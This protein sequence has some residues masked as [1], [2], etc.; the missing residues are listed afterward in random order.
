[1][2]SLITL[3]SLGLEHC[4]PFRFKVDTHMCEGLQD[5]FPQYPTAASTLAKGVYVSFRK[6][7]MVWICELSYYDNDESLAC[8]A[9]VPVRSARNS[10]RAKN[11]ARVKR[12]KEWGGVRG[13]IDR[14][15]RKPLDFEKPVRQR[16][17][18]LIGE[19]WSSWEGL[20][21]DFTQKTL[22]FRARVNIWRLYYPLDWAKAFKIFQLLF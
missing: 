16:T 18:L 12:W 17:E 10:G 11:G 21:E 2:R 14:K 7:I 8:V 13:T 22:S 19:A 4:F 5:T 20:R 1:M 3:L 6:W 15:S 9:G